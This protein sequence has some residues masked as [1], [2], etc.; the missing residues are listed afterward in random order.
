M[1]DPKVQFRHHA[2]MVFPLAKLSYQQKAVKAC[3]EPDKD[4]E[5]F[6]FPNDFDHIIITAAGVMGQNFQS[7]FITWD[8]SQ[9]IKGVQL[10]T[11]S[12]SPEWTEKG[13]STAAD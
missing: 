12:S 2:I 11:T 4:F 5:G 10:N 13:L 8:V 1:K 7:C 9:L 6:C 3:R